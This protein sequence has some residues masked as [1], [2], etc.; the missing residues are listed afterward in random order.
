MLGIDIKGLKGWFEKKEI[1]EW[2]EG[3]EGVVEMWVGK[4]EKKVVGVEIIV[5]GEKGMVV[6]WGGKGGGKCVWVK[7]VG[8]VE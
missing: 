5:R 3:V 6:I 8:V 2:F 1:V 7:R 4:D